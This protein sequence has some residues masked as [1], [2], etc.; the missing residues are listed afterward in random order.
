MGRRCDCPLREDFVR[1]A[2]VAAA[3]G[4]GPVANV[5]ATDNVVGNLINFNNDGAWSWYM[6]ERAIID[7][8]SST[9]LI[10]S[11]SLSTVLYPTGR[12]RGQDEVSS[13]N[14]STGART[15]FQVLVPVSNV[16]A[17]AD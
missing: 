16:S 4:C 8:T 15:Q 13:Y 2:L 11:N 3:L 5:S 17:L 1:L 10:G 14:L 7:P 6:D 9:L 12:Q